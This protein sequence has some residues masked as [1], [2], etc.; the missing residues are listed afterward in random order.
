MCKNING[1]D[2]KLYFSMLILGKE[3]VIYRVVVG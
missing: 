2:Y 3:E 1:D